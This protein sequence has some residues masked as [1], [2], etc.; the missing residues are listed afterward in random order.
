MQAKNLERE[1]KYADVGINAN[2]RND[3][4]RNYLVMMAAG[5]TLGL[6]LTSCD[7]D[8]EDSKCCQEMDCVGNCVDTTSYKD[9]C[10]KDKNSDIIGCCQCHVPDPNL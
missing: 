2:T 10:V 3:G 7:G 8:Y 5:I 4:I 1:V 6:G 9:Y